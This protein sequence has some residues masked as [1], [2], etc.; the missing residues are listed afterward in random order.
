M[1]ESAVVRLGEMA[2]WPD[3]CRLAYTYTHTLTPTHTLALLPTATAHCYCPLLL[4]TATA[5]CYCY[6]SFPLPF[7]TPL[8]RAG[9]FSNATASFTSLS[10]RSPI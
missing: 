5:H 2:F 3:N 9:S 8:Y 1:I 10:F 4:P 7:K 6:C